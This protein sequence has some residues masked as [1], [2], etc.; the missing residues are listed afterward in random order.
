M[1]LVPVCG[2]GTMQCR[3][4]C[5]VFGRIWKGTLSVNF[6]E[7]ATAKVVLNRSFLQID[8]RKVVNSRWF[9]VPVV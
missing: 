1:V 2:T 7:A 3:S 6:L 4:F 5:Y 9:I 8:A